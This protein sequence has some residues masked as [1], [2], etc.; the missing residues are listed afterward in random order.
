MTINQLVIGM[1][2]T[3]IIIILLSSFSKQIGLLFTFF[4]RTAVGFLSFSALNVVT[5]AIGI[6]IGINY[7]TLAFVGFLGIPGFATIY[8]LNML[9]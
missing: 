8:I 9:V 4:I 2:V 1:I 3:S 7:F 5:S 6:T